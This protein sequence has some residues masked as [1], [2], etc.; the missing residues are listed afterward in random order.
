MRAFPFS[1]FCAQSSHSHCSRCVAR[2]ALTLLSA[3]CPHVSFSCMH[4]F[5]FQSELDV[6]F[7]NAVSQAFHNIWQ[8][9]GL[10]LLGKCHG[11]KNSYAG[12]RIQNA[13]DQQP[14]MTARSTGTLQKH[15]PF[16]Q[17]H[18]LRFF[19]IFQTRQFCDSSYNNL[20][21]N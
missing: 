10:S 3:F 8:N 5:L 18:F 12:S 13:S 4:S 20:Y 15:T 19:F 1:H 7:F 9:T 16:L 17:R 11:Q 2:A 21:I 14:N 6:S